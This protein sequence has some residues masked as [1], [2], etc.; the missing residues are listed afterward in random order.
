MIPSDLERDLRS[1]LRSVLRREDII[2]AEIV[3][4]T[5]LS[6]SSRAVP[7]GQVG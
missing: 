7:V 5:N 1:E 6:T 4:H 2:I 3:I